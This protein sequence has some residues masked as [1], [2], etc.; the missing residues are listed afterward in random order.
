VQLPV[1][2]VGGGEHGVR[3]AVFIVQRGDG[4]VRAMARLL[5]SH[6][7]QVRAVDRIEALQP[8]LVD[9]AAVLVIDEEDAGPDWRERLEAIPPATRRVLLTWYP[10]AAL[11]PGVTPL[12]KPFS[13]SQLLAALSTETAPAGV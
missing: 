10:G 8:E 5:E 4:L 1:D 11:P 2:T 13:A 3:G 6:G 12:G 7:Y 9:P